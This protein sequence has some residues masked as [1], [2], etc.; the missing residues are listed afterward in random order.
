LHEGHH[1]EETRGAQ[2]PPPVPVLFLSFPQ[3]EL[4]R[5]NGSE[6]N[7]YER[8]VGIIGWLWNEHPVGFGGR[9]DEMMRSDIFHDLRARIDCRVQLLLE[10]NY[11]IKIVGQTPAW[12]LLVER[13]EISI[14]SDNSLL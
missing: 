1:A 2:F 14:K 9:L 6:Q 11:R 8:I 12:N 7:T 3:S 4:Y 5:D 13:L 10:P